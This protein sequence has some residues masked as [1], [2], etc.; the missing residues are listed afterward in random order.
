MSTIDDSFISSPDSRSAFDRVYEAYGDMV[1]RYCLRNVESEADAEELAADV[2]VALWRARHTLMEV[3]SLKSFLMTSAR[4]IVVDHYR[5]RASSLSYEM[6]V[7]T[8]HDTIADSPH[9]HMEYVEFE[10]KL[11]DAID[12]LPPTQR[13]VIRFARLDGLSVD[14]VS[15]RLGLS[16]QTVKNAMSAACKALREK[17]LCFVG[18]L[19]VLF[20]SI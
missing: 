5:R 3:R 20:T 12:S 11:L 1:L 13:N 10:Q 7:E 14:E 2:F 4:N 17:I 15:E 18:T 8:L 9:E 19:M 6:Y 16:R